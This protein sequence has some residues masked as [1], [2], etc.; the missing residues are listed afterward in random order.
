M[1]THRP[2][3][4][5]HQGPSSVRGTVTDRHQGA[6]NY[7]SSV[8]TTLNMGHF[9]KGL[10]GFSCQAVGKKSRLPML[11]GDFTKSLLLHQPAVHAHHADRPVPG[12]TA[13]SPERTLRYVLLHPLGQTSGPS[14]GTV[15]TGILQ[16]F[17]NRP[18]SWSP[19]VSGGTCKP[20]DNLVGSPAP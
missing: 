1:S 6:Q 12:V 14:T 13:P 10:E 9:Q 7:A 20:R 15:C 2:M 5:E 17:K 3:S 16:E 4:R 18:K 19:G 8:R 11:L